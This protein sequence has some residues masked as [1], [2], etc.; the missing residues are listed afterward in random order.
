M[1]VWI[2]IYMYMHTYIYVYVYVCLFVCVCVNMFLCIYVSLCMPM[3]TYVYVFSAY[4]RIYVCVRKSVWMYYVWARVYLFDFC[5]S[6]L[7]SLGLYISDTIFPPSHPFPSPLTHP[8]QPSISLSNCCLSTHLSTFPPSPDTNP[9][10]VSFLLTIRVFFYHP[11]PPFLMT[12]F[13]QR[14]R[15]FLKIFTCFSR[16]L[17]PFLHLFF[18]LVIV[19][20]IFASIIVIIIILLLR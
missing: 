2:Y 19:K 3:F 1:Y 5:H 10:F 20:I 9:Q 12:S 11:I 6:H 18:C 14:H 13:L 16:C 7:C 4:V 15:Q 17:P 8:L